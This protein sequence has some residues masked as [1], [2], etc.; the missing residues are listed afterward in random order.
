MNYAVVLSGLLA[1]GQAHAE[2]DVGRGLIELDKCEAAGGN[3]NLNRGSSR[4]FEEYVERTKP[5]QVIEP[6]RSYLAYP[7]ADGK[8]ISVYGGTGRGFDRE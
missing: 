4:E 6:N 2:C 1:L 3:G 8:T 5:I 7:S